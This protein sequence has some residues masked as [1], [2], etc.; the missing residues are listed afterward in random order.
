MSGEAAS[1][2]CGSVSIEMLYRAA[3]FAMVL[4]FTF[5]LGKSILHPF[6]K[7][8]IAVHAAGQRLAV[9]VRIDGSSV[10]PDE[11]VLVVV[12][13]VH[14]AKDEATVVPIIHQEDMMG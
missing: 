14:Q 11:L 8:R 6:A 5:C 10:R 1:C 2:C 4:L 9:D 12:P 3:T 13:I 7:A